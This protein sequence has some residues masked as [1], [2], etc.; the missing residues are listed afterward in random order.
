[1]LVVS[2]Q[3]VMTRLLTP[4]AMPRM[5]YI[6]SL[7]RWF[8]R[9]YAACRGPWP[10]LE[11]EIPPELLS[12]PGIERDPAAEAAAFKAR[13]L[14]SFHHDYGRSVV[15]ALQRLWQAMIPVGPRLMRAIDHVGRTAAAARAEPRTGE[16]SPAVLTERVRAWAAEIGLSTIGITGFDERYAYADL[17]LKAWDPTIIVCVLEQNWEATQA[18]PSARGE[19]T[20]LST[21]AELMELVSLLARRLQQNGFRAIPHTTEGRGVVQHFA[22]EAGIGQMGV[23][24]Q[25]LTPVAGSRI[26]MALISTVA[27]LAHDHPVDYGINGICDRCQ[28]CVRR[29]P[30]GAIPAAR[31]PHRGVVKSKL[32]LS[33]CFPVVAQVHGCSIC[34]KVCPVQRY[35]LPQVLD[36]YKS[37]G[38]ILGKGSE[39]LESYLWPLDGIRYGVAER[40]RLIP[41]F[42]QVPGFMPGEPPPEEREHA[43]SVH[44]P[45]M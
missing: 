39:E 9:R 7:P 2:L 32:N 44:N 35:G 36:H 5:R 23:N 14:Y 21:N 45:L 24:G 13:P 19:Q 4:R 40:P 6:P 18:I 41:G 8:R 28:V 34:M 25:L 11:L 37:T 26:R 1:L 15:W 10:A 30:S 33:R 3:P 31:R 12:A 17:D 16:V 42:F 43:S 29:C 20:A 22:V 38:E 27:E